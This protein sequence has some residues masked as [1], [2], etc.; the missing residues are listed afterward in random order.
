MRWTVNRE[1]WDDY[2]VFGEM[3]ERKDSEVAHCVGAS[4]GE[5][6]KIQNATVKCEQF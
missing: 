5:G 3:S 1:K 4:L 2:R 6:L